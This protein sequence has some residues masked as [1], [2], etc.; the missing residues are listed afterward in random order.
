MLDDF[1]KFPEWDALPS[2]LDNELIIAIRERDAAK[3]RL[4]IK[5]KQKKVFDKE[6]GKHWKDLAQKLE[7]LRK[8][9]LRH[10][11]FSLVYENNII[12]M[13]IHY[14]YFKINDDTDE[15]NFVHIF[16]QT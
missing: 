13:I 16:P 15:T 5:R 7:E 2:A 12:M 11:Q 8:D 14:K 9:E 10:E 1:R 3:T 6:M 4:E